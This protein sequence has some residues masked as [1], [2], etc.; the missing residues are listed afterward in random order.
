MRFRLLRV[1]L[2][3]VLLSLLLSVPVEAAQS[4]YVGIFRGTTSQMRKGSGDLFVLQSNEPGIANEIDVVEAYTG[5]PKCAAW[6]TP[7][8]HMW[9]ISA[10]IVHN[11]FSAILLDGIPHRY[12]ALPNLTGRDVFKVT[13]TVSANGKTI[14]GAFSETRPAAAKHPAYVCK[15]GNVKYTATLN[16]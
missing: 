13:G 12:G 6:N 5:S 4:Y 9:T 16:G 10:Q 14:A 2:I 8:P 1:L 11:K 7:A 3:A 15:T